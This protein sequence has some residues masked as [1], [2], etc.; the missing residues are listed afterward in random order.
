M[1]R[2][3]M[4]LNILCIVGQ[5]TFEYKDFICKQ[6]KVNEKLSRYFAEFVFY[7]HFKGRFREM[8]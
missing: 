7:D 8:D 6:Q 3:N 1:F 2:D 4:H 5:R